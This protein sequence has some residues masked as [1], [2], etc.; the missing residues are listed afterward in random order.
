MKDE[1]DNTE[2]LVSQEDILEELVGEIRD[3][4]DSE[5][6]ETIRPSG[7]NA[8]QVM[9]RLHVVDFNRQTGWEVPAERGETLAGLTFNVLARAPRKGDIAHVA[10][11]DL[12][13]IDVSGTR[14]TR[15][16]VRQ[17]P[18]PGPGEAVGETPSPGA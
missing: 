10:G 18:A 16:L 14:I 1:F 11:Y 4:F 6:L 8:Y 13:V 15:V 5:E 9:G 2:G 17:R 3:E 7:E 12:G